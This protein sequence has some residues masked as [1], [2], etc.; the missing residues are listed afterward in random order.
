MILLLMCLRKDLLK[1]SI[2]AGIMNLEVGIVILTLTAE[3]GIA[4]LI[5]TVDAGK[6][7]LIGITN[8]NLLREVHLHASFLLLEIVGM[9]HVADFLIRFKKILVQIGGP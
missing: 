1:M 2:G 7:I 4:I 6:L 8:M 5:L 3:V 9:E